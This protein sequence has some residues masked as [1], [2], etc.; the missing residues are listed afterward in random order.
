MDAD[1]TWRTYVAV[2]VA[3]VAMALAVCATFPDP[4]WLIAIV[5]W[6]LSFYNAQW[7]WEAWKEEASDGR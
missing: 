6:L 5:P 4:F 2:M 7:A 1:P 3:Y